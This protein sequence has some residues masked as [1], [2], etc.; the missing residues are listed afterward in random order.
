MI[1]ELETASDGEFGA[2]RDGTRGELWWVDRQAH[3]AAQ[4]S[5]LNG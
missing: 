5:T 1:F 3:T 2:T 4:L